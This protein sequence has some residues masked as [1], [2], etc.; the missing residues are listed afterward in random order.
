MTLN[1]ASQTITVTT[2]APLSTALFYPKFSNYGGGFI[3]CKKAFDALGLTGLKTHPVGTGPFVFQSYTP[4]EKVELTANADYFLGKPKLA[5]VEFRYMPDLNS[6]EAGLVSGQLDVANGT[7]DIKWAQRMQGN[8]GVKVDIFGAGEVQLIHFCTTCAPLD[9]LE[10]RQAIAYALSRDEFQALAGPQVSEQ[11]FSPIPAQ[12][13]A[14]GLTRDEVAAAGLDYATDL[15]KAKALLAQAGL[16][17]GFSI[18]LVEA[19]QISN[20]SIYE[21]MQAQ[22]AK[23]GI[24][25]N[26]TTVDLASYGTQVR[27]G[28]NAIV[29]Y[30][31][32]RPNADVYLTQFFHSDSIIVTGKTPNTN[33]SRYSAIDDVITQARSE[34][35]AT[36]QVALWKDAQT[37]ILQDMAAY[38]IQYLNQVY[39]RSDKVDYGHPL[40][41]VLALYP[42][43]DETTSLAH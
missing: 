11:V 20:S 2:P 28:S 43:I 4:G 1:K 26:L 40:K 31:A 17:D 15:N 18:D 10:V 5:G 34:P 6:R 30:A 24:K 13:M 16:P 14:G 22:L 41:S 42:G 27:Q 39:A 37:H 3:I 19:Q 32:L 8:A 23:I 29:V 35:D 36:K 38:P 9:K 7:P 25:L 33:F 21:S 12:F